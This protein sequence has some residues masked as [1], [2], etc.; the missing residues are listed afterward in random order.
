MEV[1]NEHNFDDQSQVEVYHLPPMLLPSIHKSKAFDFKEMKR[2]KPPSPPVD[3][4][5]FS[6]RSRRRRAAA[7]ETRM[8]ILLNKKTSF[9][10]DRK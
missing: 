9:L 5:Y 2:N 1:R 6:P 8:S 4:F 7:H 3:P 10:L